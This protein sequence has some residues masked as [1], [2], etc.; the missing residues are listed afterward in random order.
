MMGRKFWAGF[1]EDKLAIREID[2]GFGG[3]GSGDGKL[4]APALFPSKAAARK[5]YQDVRLVEVRVIQPTKFR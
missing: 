5:Q 1:C 2:T 4:R 3:F